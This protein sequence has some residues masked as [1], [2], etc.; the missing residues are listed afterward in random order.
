MRAILLSLALTLILSVSVHAEEVQDTQEVWTPS[1]VGEL[2]PDGMIPQEATYIVANQDTLIDICQKFINHYRYPF[3]V[4]EWVAINLGI[5]PDRLMPGDVLHVPNLQRV[6]RVREL[7]TNPREPWDN[8][9]ILVDINAKL[10][11]ITNND[12]G[13]RLAYPIGIGKSKTPT[14]RGT[15]VVYEILDNP[16]FRRSNGS[17]VRTSRLKQGQLLPM[18]WAPLIAIGLRMESGAIRYRIHSTTDPHTVGYEL[19][20]G[21]IRMNIDDALELRQLVLDPAETGIETPGRIR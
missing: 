13:E 1:V 20:N 9:T 4:E 14:P 10:L 12:T 18:S 19:S 3:I 8:A 17:R 21:C 2:P 6:R 5:N 7:L 16:V 11:T 15:F